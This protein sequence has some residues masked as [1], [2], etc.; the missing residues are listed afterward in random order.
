MKLIVGLGN[1]GGEYAQT[2]HNIGFFVIDK[3]AKELATGE[4]R[5][6]ADHDHKSQVVTMSGVILVKPQT[7]M[8]SS[9]VAV[10]GLAKYYKIIPSDIIVVHDDLDLPV[11][12]I[13]LRS[14]GGSGG[15]NGVQSVLDALKSDMF[16]RVKLGIG[17]SKEVASGKQPEKLRR[18]QAVIN[19]VLSKFRRSEAGE[20]R[21]LVDHGAR[22]VRMILTEG[23]DKA[24]N[25]FH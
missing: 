19:F 4:V 7:F 16:V 6:Q 8:N 3:L 11:G 21:K 13:R 14:R 17:R 1:P 24:T 18:H 9:G 23:L 20:M 25:K 2:R 22:A 5:W 12:K 10:A 15:H